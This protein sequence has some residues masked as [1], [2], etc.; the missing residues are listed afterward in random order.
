MIPEEDLP[1]PSPK[2]LNEAYE[3]LSKP[4]FSVWI[5]LMTIP[6]IER[7]TG[8]TSLSKTLRLSVSQLNR[9]LV[10]LQNK[11]YVGLLRKPGKKATEI[12]LLRVAMFFEPADFVYY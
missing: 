7:L 3:E 6:R 12:A 4:A 9:I 5:R 8:R 11:G 1:E 10:E 2:H